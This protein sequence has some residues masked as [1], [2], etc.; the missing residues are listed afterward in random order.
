MG[1]NHFM[2]M[3]WNGIVRGLRALTCPARKVCLPKSLV[4]QQNNI[5][6]LHISAW[7]DVV[8]LLSSREGNSLTTVSA[9]QFTK[10]HGERKGDKN[11]C[12]LTK[13]DDL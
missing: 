2:T 3:A 7:R 1:P 13:S 10:I 4:S 8:T 11:R 6:P 12:F 5:M 9:G